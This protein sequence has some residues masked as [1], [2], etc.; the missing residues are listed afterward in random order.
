[1]EVGPM[2]A[3]SLVLI[4]LVFL[5]VAGGPGALTAS[6]SPAPESNRGFASL[7]AASSPPVERE[8]PAVRP[9]ALGSSDPCPA[10]TP[11][12]SA[13]PT[14]SPDNPSWAHRDPYAPTTTWYVSPDRK[15]WAHP[16]NEWS[17]RSGIK[18]FWIK[19]VGSQLEVSG[20]RLDGPA[21]PLGVNLPS[22]YPGDY[23]AGGLTFPV[24][25]CWEVE[26]KAGG[27]VLRFVVSVA[28]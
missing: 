23:Q 4:S 13:D 22:G 18:V 15:L 3:P 9:R 25:G 19:P 7:D 5:V 28:A 24:A 14:P 27:S 16:W 11:I 20:R 2:R 1:M 17:T 26:S 8:A 10:T 6:P 21:P 12:L